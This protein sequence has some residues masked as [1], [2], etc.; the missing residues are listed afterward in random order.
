MVEAFYLAGTAS[1]C[2]ARLAEYHAAGVD[3]P[4]LLPRLEDYQTTVE[5]LRSSASPQA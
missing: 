5:V 3:L 4:L 1:Q 2:R